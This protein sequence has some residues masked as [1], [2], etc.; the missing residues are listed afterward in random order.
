MSPQKEEKI[1]RLQDEYKSA[2]VRAGSGI[3][4][5]TI[6]RVLC[7]YLCESLARFELQNC[8]TLTFEGRKEE[9]YS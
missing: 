5:L 6:V 3:F 2:E 9:L 1:S 8:L 7:I 4:K